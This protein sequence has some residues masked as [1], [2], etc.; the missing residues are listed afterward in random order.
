MLPESYLQPMD[1]RY[2]S[3]TS[4]HLSDR[5]KARHRQGGV[6]LLEVMIAVLV[7]AVGVLGAASLQLNAIRYSASAGHSTQAALA[8]RDMLD[9]MRANPSELSRY[10]IA[11]VAGVCQVNPGG[12]DIAAQDLA[13]FAIWFEQQNSLKRQPCGRQYQPAHVNHELFTLRR[14]KSSQ[15]KRKHD[16]RHS[17]RRGL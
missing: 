9:R 5:L 15:V 8:A 16:I 2:S 13:D 3:G 4:A 7:L 6:S 14:H 10:A 17:P 12:A 11:S 1:K